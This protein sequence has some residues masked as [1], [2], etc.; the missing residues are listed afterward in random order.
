ML[1]GGSLIR[2]TKT[3][4]PKAL[5]P[6]N[7]KFYSTPTKFTLATFKVAQNTLEKLNY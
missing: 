7:Q 1:N 3:L 2:G 6:R 4:Q 5:I